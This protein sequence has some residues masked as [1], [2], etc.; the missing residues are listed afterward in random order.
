MR[1]RHIVSALTTAALIA[2]TPVLAQ[3]RGGGAGGGHKGG[4]SGGHGG[5]MGSP[6][7]AGG[8]GMELPRRGDN[9]DFGRTTRD[10][11]RQNARAVERAA[12]R[13]RQ[14]ANE[15]GVLFGTTGTARSTNGTTTRAG[16][17][18]NSQ[19][20]AHAS[21]T[22]IAHAN[23]NSVLSGTT[24]VAGPLTGLVAG[25][26]VMGA[27]G[28]RVGT[29]SRIVASPDGM[30]RNVLVRT[31]D[32]RIIP[33]AANSLQLNGSTLTALSMLPNFNRR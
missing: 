33:L 21:A 25:A 32:G 2:A 8:G 26:P 29:I 28:M 27:D 30:V 12:E 23:S 5:G 1:T 7:R 4:M 11:A 3:G 31:T 14:K 20:P 15:N 16:A 17:R 22:G 9:G 24:V 10:E 13:A 19:G 18:A 6:G